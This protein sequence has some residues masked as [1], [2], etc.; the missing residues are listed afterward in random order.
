LKKQI[1]QYVDDLD[2]TVLED[3]DGGTIRFSLEGRQYE[4]D[5]SEEN[6][7]GLRSALAPYISA[8]RTVSTG[9]R[10][11]TSGTRRPSRSTGGDLAAIR[12]WAQS[13]GFSVGD[14]GRISAEVRE[15]Y[16]QAN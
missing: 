2:G 9:S 12:S 1:T 7:D 16:D 11:S 6:A 8:A 14:R 4:I 13:N 15:A 3:G 5:L 10:P